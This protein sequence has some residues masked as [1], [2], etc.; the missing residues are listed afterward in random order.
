MTSVSL[1]KGMAVVA[2]VGEGM[3]MN[4]GVTATFMSALANAN[5]N[6]RWVRR[7]RQRGGPYR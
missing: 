3:A 2:I 5:V 1:Q 4:L 7:E 6:I